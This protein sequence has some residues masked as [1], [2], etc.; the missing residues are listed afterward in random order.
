MTRIKSL[1]T[2]VDSLSAEW[3][4]LKEQRHT[5]PVTDVSDD[6][7]QGGGDAGIL[8]SFF[9]KLPNKKERNCCVCSAASTRLDTRAPD[10]G[11]WEDAHAKTPGIKRA[12]IVFVDCLKEQLI[13]N[14]KYRDL[15]G[16]HGY[17]NKS[18]VLQEMSLE[19]VGHPKWQVL[20][21]MYTRKSTIPYLL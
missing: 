15:Q 21:V 11:T 10:A 2:L 7:N 12:S 13:A 20:F 19:L 18:N 14:R 8:S 3:F 1:V 9:E 16:V 5:I 4:D 6:E 17:N